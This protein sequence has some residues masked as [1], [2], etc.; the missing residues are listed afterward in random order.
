[1][2]KLNRPNCPHLQ[3]LKNQDY[4]H[5]KNREALKIANSDK[6]MYCESKISHSSFPNIEHIK[7]KSKFP[8]LTYEWENLGYVCARC[9]NAK[10]DKF[11][12]ENPFL[13]PYSE[14][15][16]LHVYAFGTLLHHKKGSEK[17]EITIHEIEL[18]RL[19]LI[20][21]RKVRL[22]SVQKAMVACYRTKSERLRDLAIQE[23]FREA[24]ADKEYS[25]F[26]KTLFQVSLSDSKL[27]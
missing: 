16:S 26:V 15:P 7:P 10:L 13:D 12:E 27:P 17:G 4:K 1:M 2:I 18:N 23:L 21:K 25:L 3:A 5:P 20:E 14:D 9:N 22:D 11:D 8:E 19:E 24:E 6:C